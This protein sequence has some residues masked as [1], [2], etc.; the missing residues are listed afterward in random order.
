MEEMFQAVLDSQE[1]TRRSLESR[2]DK[3]RNEFKT[4]LDLKIKGLKEEVDLSL[5]HLENDISKLGDR[6][7]IVENAHAGCS[8]W[9]SEK[10]F[11]ST[12]A[13]N[14]KAKN[15]KFS[16]EYT[17]IAVGLHEE[18]DENL[19]EKVNDLIRAM[20][21]E[22]INI[23]NC[24]RLNSKISGRPGLVKIEFDSVDQKIEV[25]KNK[26]KLS[27]YTAFKRVFLRSS[28]THLERLY[29][30]NTRTLLKSLPEGYKFK[31]TAN[32]KL[33]PKEPRGDKGYRRYT[34]NYGP[35]NNKYDE[36]DMGGPQA[37]SQE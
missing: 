17:V 16:V 37:D 14:P 19:L 7:G 34:K 31:L 24:T 23:V 15:E 22:D 30:S 5:A 29:E 26:K 32:G 28:K 8:V 6:L 25:L 20:E 21:L 18:Q 2:I 13:K 36:D 11:N 3:L 12:Q 10:E 35:Q 4:E 33:V 9:N 1:R 27:E